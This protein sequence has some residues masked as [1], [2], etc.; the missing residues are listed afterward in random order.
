MIFFKQPYL[1]KFLDPLSHLKVV[2]IGS[3]QCR[4]NQAILT[5]STALTVKKDG[6]Q[7]IFILKFVNSILSLE[8]D[9]PD[10]NVIQRRL[11]VLFNDGTVQH[12]DEHLLY[13]SS[14]H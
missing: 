11:T 5:S 8:S 12:A 3:K 7:N 2:G 4:F 9:E 13:N 1:W 14:I 10:V 6:Q